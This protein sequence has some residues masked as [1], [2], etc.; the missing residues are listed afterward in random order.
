M[1]H[2]ASTYLIHN[3]LPLFPIGNVLA[4]EVEEAQMLVNTAERA[5]RNAD[6]EVSY[7]K[8]CYYSKD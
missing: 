6:N 2:Y 3:V 7:N 4:S 5:K 1:P 8:S